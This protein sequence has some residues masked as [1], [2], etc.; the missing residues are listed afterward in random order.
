MLL[1]GM[2][3]KTNS[4]ISVVQSDLLDITMLRISALLFVGV[5]ADVQKEWEDF[6]MTYGKTYNGD[7]EMKMLI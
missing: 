5:S 6:K 4:S 7:E 3:R 2:L 1:V